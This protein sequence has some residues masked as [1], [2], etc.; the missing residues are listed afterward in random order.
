MTRCENECQNRQPPRVHSTISCHSASF[1]L[2]PL[3]RSGCLTATS[4]NRSG[5]LTTTIDLQLLQMGKNKQK[6]KASSSSPSVKVIG[7]LADES[8]IRTLNVANQEMGD[9]V[10]TISQE[11][12][13]HVDTTF[14]LRGNGLIID[15]D[16]VLIPGLPPAHLA[17]QLKLMKII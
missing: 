7:V 5:C 13:Q 4:A 3:I 8:A 10:S 12:K 11:L 14:G 16:T 9:A 6:Q 2:R 1:P 17:V 15:A